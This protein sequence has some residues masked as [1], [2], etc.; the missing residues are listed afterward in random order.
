M[1]LREL[2]HKEGNTRGT[3]GLIC[4]ICNKEGKT[5]DGIKEEKRRGSIETQKRAADRDL[6]LCEW[7][8]LKLYQA[9][10]LSLV[11]LTSTRLRMSATM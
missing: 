11:D 4:G 1:A 6:Q 9:A 10:F 2:L 3:G 8:S 5:A 7:L